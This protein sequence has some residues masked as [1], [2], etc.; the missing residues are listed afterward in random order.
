[1]TVQEVID[2]LNSAGAISQELL[3]IIAGLDPQI[4]LPL[5]VAGKVEPLVIQLVTAALTAWGA[6]AQTPITPDTVALLL[7]NPTPLTPPKD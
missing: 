1:M 4:A 7:S 5:D 2:A 3:A 6:A